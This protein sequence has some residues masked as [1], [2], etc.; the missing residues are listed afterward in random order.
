LIRRATPYAVSNWALEALS[1]RLACRMKAFGVRVA[2][3]EPGIID[4]AMGT[5]DQQE[6][7]L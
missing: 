7:A 6:R 4:T 5:K 2:L 1:E 3:F